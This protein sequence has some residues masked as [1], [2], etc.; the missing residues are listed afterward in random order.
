MADELRRI[1]NTDV[2]SGVANRRRFDESMEH[3]WR[4]AR[5]YGD[6][7][8]LLMVDV[9]HF[10]PYNDRYG[11]PAGDA[12]LRLVAQAMVGASLRAADLVARYGGE[13]FVVLLPLT[14][15]R[16][17]EYVANNILYAVEALN[18]AHETSPTARHVTVSIGIGCYDDESASW[19]SPTADSRLVNGRPQGYSAVDLVRCADKALYSA[20]NAGRAKARLLDIADVNERQAARDIGPSRRLAFAHA[21]N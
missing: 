2:V 14:R 1:S 15:R 11:H 19:V 5:R 3:E 7:V 12:C 18:I 6:P 21:L 16:G 10:K 13:E 20:K 8:A 9:D 17:A 4:R